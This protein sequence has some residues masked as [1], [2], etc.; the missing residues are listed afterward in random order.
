M[1]FADRVPPQARNAYEKDA[2]AGALTAAMSGLT[3]PFVAVIARD[4]LQATD[5]QIA[6][7][8]MSGVAGHLFAIYW[9]KM[10]EGR[11]KMPFA[12]TAYAIARVPLLFMCLANSRFTFVGLTI[13]VNLLTSVAAPAYSALMREIYPDSDRARVMGYVRALNWVVLI[14]A[15]GLASWLLGTLTYKVVFPVAGL[16]GIA[17]ALVFGRIPSRDASGDAD[18]GHIEF[19]RDSLSILRD[20]RP[21]LWFSAGVFMFGFANFI[22]LPVWTIYQVDVL[23]VRTQWAGLYSITVQLSTLVSFLYWGGYVDRSRPEKSVAL[24]TVITI[25]VPLIYC[26]SSEPWM[27]L[28]AMLVWGVV[29][30][31]TELSYMRGVLYYAPAK[32]VAQ[33]QA[34]FMVLMGLR[35]IA[36][37]YIGTA[38]LHSGLLT[39]RGVFMLEAVLLVVAVGIQVV[40]LRKY[41]REK[42]I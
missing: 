41:G 35:G 12:V 42:A 31:G 14:A 7:L 18:V 19:F 20:D 17:G 28:P 40:A 1:F 6:L 36:G 4:T 24:Q 23:G 32:R 39:M 27:L 10:I 26:V 30:A 8:S 9:A 38:L 29:C 34:L 11:R 5:F 25:A 16:L 2:V 37:P 22:A 21:F 3:G 33:Y 13:A 15:T